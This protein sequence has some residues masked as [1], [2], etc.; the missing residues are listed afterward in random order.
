MKRMDDGHDNDHSVE[1]E[2]TQ[3]FAS[4]IRVRVFTNYYPVL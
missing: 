2:Q 3:R 1:V 4:S